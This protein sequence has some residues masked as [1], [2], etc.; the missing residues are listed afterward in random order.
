MSC[1]VPF[2][3]LYS[4]LHY[5]TGFHGVWSTTQAEHQAQLLEHIFSN[6]TSYVR[7]VCDQDQPIQVKI[8]I[9][10]R[11]I[12]ELDEPKQ[13]LYLNAWVRLSWDDCHMTWDPNNFGNISNIVVPF[14]RVWSPDIT[15]YDNGDSEL[16]GSKDYLIDIEHT[17][18]LIYHYPTIIKVLCR[19]DVVYFPF[20][21]QVCPLKFG[22]WS[23]H[24][25][26]INVTNRDSAGDMTSFVENT[27]WDLLSL[28]LAR[29][30][31]KY[32][33]CPEPY[34]DVT[35]YVTMKRKPLFYV[36]NLLFPCLLI[37]AVALL[38]KHLFQSLY[39]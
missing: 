7:P 25:F 20:D 12:I 16:E 34:P 21:T 39:Q 5:L 13:I 31:L 24:G 26:E 35:F 8:D 37:T 38:G 1:G 6:Y 9:A 19:I 15:L 27:E 3:L 10:I 22:S 28:P 4:L 2:L 11:Q 33:C 18:I 17:G 23:Y 30:E 14:Q 36:L 32:G 29:H